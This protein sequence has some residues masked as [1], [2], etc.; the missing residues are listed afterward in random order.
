MYIYHHRGH[1]RIFS[2]KKAHDN[3]RGY[4]FYG[5]SGCIELVLRIVDDSRI[6][7]SLCAARTN[8]IVFA[9]I[10]DCGK[11]A[12]KSCGILCK[13][14]FVRCCENIRTIKKIA[15]KYFIPYVGE[16]KK[17]KKVVENL[18]QYGAEVLYNIAIEE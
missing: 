1:K 2:S 7:K 15:E 14:H 9:D 12:E 4:H 17:N 13:I 5:H 8:D 18:L 16:S 11:A 6:Y 3:C 10:S